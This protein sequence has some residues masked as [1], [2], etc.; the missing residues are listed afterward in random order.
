MAEL[1]PPE[2]VV[3]MVTVPELFLATVI[4]VGDA[5]IVKFGLVPVTVNDTVVVSTVLPEVPVTVMGYVP[6]TVVEA[7]VIDIVEVPAPVIDAGLKPMVTPVGCPLAVRLIVPLK[8]PVTVLVMVELPEPPCAID[9]EAGD[10]ERVNPGPDD[11]P[12]SA[13]SRPLAFG[14]PQPLA[15]SYPVVAE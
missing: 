13:F 15:R 12:A 1:N 4:D 14:L 9:T 3:V 7:T 8:P 5:L 2:T 11:V 10:A 6:A